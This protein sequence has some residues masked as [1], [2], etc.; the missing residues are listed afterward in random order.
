MNRRD[1]LRIGTAAAAT[2]LSAQSYARVMGAN[3]RVGLGIIGLGRRG[4]IV[5]GMGFLRDARSQVVALCD[6][7]EAQTPRFVSRLL[8]N[9]PSP[10]SSYRYQDI[11]DHKDV[12]AVYIAT[13]DH[14]HVM[15][16]TAALDAGKNVYLEKPTLHHWS[17]HTAL[18]AAA[19]KSP[20]VLQCGMQQRS[21]A[22]YMQAKQ[23]L[24]DQKK[25]G[26]VVFARGTWDNFPWQARKIGPKPEPPGMHWELFEG[27]A[28][29]VPW[30]W[31]RYTSWRYFPD[32][33]NGL[34]ADIMTHWVDVAQWMMNDA[35]PKTAA[36]LGGI[37]QLHDGRVNPDTVS[38]IVQYTDWNFNF[39]STVLPVRD[40][41]PSVYFEGT[42]G[43]LML[44]RDGY[45]YTPNEG[46][47]VRVD[48]RESLERQHTRNFLDAVVDGKA[49]NASVQAGI[50]ASV[51]V[52]MALQS[53]WSHKMI[54]RPE[55]A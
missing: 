1:F 5:T 30:A 31:I 36:A 45:T 35:N 15:I 49:T 32:Y 21:G 41:H 14:L 28:P 17:E 44:A 34:L 47:P 40:P 42:E 10:Y 9:Q 51:P 48:A 50:D 11:L 29:H 27:P 37:Y 12:D 3:S 2:T 53:Y 43:T 46:Q 25:L 55:L 7:Y 4:T 23:E 22:H 39:E 16:A 33:G 19:R 8:G 18:L 20:K 26:H 6:V 54:T 24:F 38:A 13:P 52:Q